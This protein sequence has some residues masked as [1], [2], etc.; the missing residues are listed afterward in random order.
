MFLLG[1]LNRFCLD[2]LKTVFTQAGL[3]HVGI[4]VEARDQRR[5]DGKVGS[6]NFLNGCTQDVRRGV[7]EDLIWTQ[8]SLDDG[9]AY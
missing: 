3:A 7:P 1:H 8:K 2:Q 4:I 9:L 5:T 6:V